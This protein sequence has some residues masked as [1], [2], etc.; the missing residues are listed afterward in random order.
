M[1][2]FNIDRIRQIVGE[3]NLSL[4]KIENLS[5]VSEDEFLTSQ[6]KIDSAKYNLIVAIEG[7]IDICNHIV[8]KAG[9]RAPCDYGDCFTVLSELGVITKDEADKLKKMVKFRNI[10]V[11]LY[12]KV[13]NKKVYEI[14]KKDIIDIRNYLKQIG[15]F[16]GES[17]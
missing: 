7:S 3:V 8:A 10:L 15:K 5:R 12:F 16:I 11:H 1:P 14:M 9:G 2:K 6:E 4:A 17:I 13:D